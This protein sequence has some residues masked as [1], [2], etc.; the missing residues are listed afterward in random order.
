M[1]DPNTL[2]LTA[3]MTGAIEGTKAMAEQ[4]I[5]DGYQGLKTLIKNK[6]LGNPKAE[7]VLK[8]YEKNPE[9]WKGPLEETIQEQKL[10]QNVEIVQAAQN[11]L[12]LVSGD[13]AEGSKY[14]VQIKNSQG[15][16]VGDNA[17]TTINIGKMT[18]NK[19]AK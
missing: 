10:D 12:M 11:F 9:T 17:K 15:V 1:I 18:K 19:S 16:I 13:H 14:Q 2:I 3:L 5:K 6:V 8:E 4:A 7:M